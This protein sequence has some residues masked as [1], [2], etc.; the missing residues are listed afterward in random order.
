[1]AAKAAALQGCAATVALPAKTNPQMGLKMELEG[2]QMQ[3][4]L[5][6]RHKWIK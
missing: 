1:M 5:H 4:V 2:A 6:H 3:P